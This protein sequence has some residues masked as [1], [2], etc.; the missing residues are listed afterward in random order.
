PQHHWLP[1]Q[2]DADPF[3]NVAHGGTSLQLTQGIGTQVAALPPLVPV[4]PR[5]HAGQTDRAN[6][7][8]GVSV[9][10]LQNQAVQTGP[11]NPGPYT[12][13]LNEICRH[14]ESTVVLNPSV[15]C[16]CPAFNPHQQRSPSQS[17]SPLQHGHGVGRDLIQSP[18]HSPSPPNSMRMVRSL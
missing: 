18:S 16:G 15:P 4:H 7:F 11:N 2:P 1:R 5:G 12:L 13:P 14:A 10:E 3:V 9:N 8:M 6:P 17:V